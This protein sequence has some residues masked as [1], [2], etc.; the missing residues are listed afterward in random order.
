MQQLDR[1]TED[2]VVVNGVRVHFGRAGSGPPLV[3]VHGLVGSVANW[4]R[5]IDQLAKYATVY[6]VDLANMGRS[7]RVRGLDGKSR[8]RLL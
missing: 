8:L 6:A 1:M 3:L 4:R 7:E 2:F 5:N